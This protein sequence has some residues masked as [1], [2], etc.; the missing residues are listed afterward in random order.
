MVALAA[1][2]T[3]FSCIKIESEVETINLGG[4]EFYVEVG[5]TMTINAVLL[6]ES[7]SDAAL[8][9][10]SD[11]P[12]VAVVNNG[13]VTALKEGRATV[14]VRAESG[15]T[16]SC[17]ICV[18]PVITGVSLPSALT[19]YVGGSTVLTPK[20]S[21]EGTV[22][23]GLIWTSEDES[24]A[25]VS[26]TGLVTGVDGGRTMVT[27]RYKEYTATCQVKVREA[28]IGVELDITEADLAVG[29][30]ELQLT[31]LVTPSNSID[32]ELEWSTSDA[33]VALVSENGVVTPVGPG[34]AV[35]TASVDMVYQ[36]VCHIRVTQPAEGVVISRTELKIQIGTSETL[37]ATVR[38]ETANVKELIWSSSDPEVASVSEDG[39]VTAQKLGETDVVVTTVD[40][41]YTASCKVIVIQ[42]VTGV[43]LDVGNASM[44]VGE[45]Y[46]LNATVEPSDASDKS[47]VWTS[48]SSKVASVNETGLVTPLAP[49]ECVITVTTSDG[50]FTAECIIVVT[51][52]F[53]LDCTYKRLAVGESFKLTPIFVQPD[54]ADMELTWESSDEETVRVD[55]YGN[56]EAVGAGAATITVKTKNGY[57][58]SC[59]I[60]VRPAGSSDNE[61]FAEEDD[62][63]WN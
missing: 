61:G 53:D 33:E 55:S 28:A 15:V 60:V 47:L 8:V 51:R 48:S 10:T 49:G 34:E 36:A 43:S 3:L 27:V 57:T 1:V 54:I 30:D 63:R 59:N 20:F 6:P 29:V 16:A 22:S 7:A 19:V 56:V 35:I 44:I 14:L 50:G 62:F 46:Q 32:Y 2:I 40:G 26:Q 31:A 42:R 12:E 21:P 24:V 58:A 41:G 13:V 18:T 45:P 25:T 4:S 39:T 9:W 52:P 5:G 23:S 38:P 37:E 11:T 17:V